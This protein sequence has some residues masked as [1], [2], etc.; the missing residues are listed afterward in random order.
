MKR[1]K[2]VLITLS[3]LVILLIGFFS[4]SKPKQI[5]IAEYNPNYLSI[6]PK[7]N[8]IKFENKDFLIKEIYK[9]QLNLLT[10]IQFSGSEGFATQKVDVSDL[11]KTKEKAGFPK[12]LKFK[13]KDHEIIY[14]SQSYPITEQR[15]DS[16]LSK[17]NENKIILFIN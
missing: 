10:E 2:F 16:I 9:Y 3:L 17:N 14:N 11:I 12:F 5:L 13:K 1:F 4:F 7:T 8:F 6:Y 15:L